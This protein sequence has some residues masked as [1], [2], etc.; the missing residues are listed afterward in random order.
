MDLCTAE[1][2][3]EK[4]PVCS[5]QSREVGFADEYQLLETD[6]FSC[7][8]CCFAEGL[9]H[10]SHFRNLPVWLLCFLE[11]TV[12]RINPWR[13]E[14]WC[15]GV[16]LRLC[17]CPVLITSPVTEMFCLGYLEISASASSDGLLMLPKAL[18]AYLIKAMSALVP[19]CLAAW[20]EDLLLQAAEKH[21]GRQRGWL[22]KEILISQVPTFQFIFTKG[23]IKLEGPVGTEGTCYQCCNSEGCAST[24]WKPSVFKW[25]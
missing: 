13:G 14:G 17:F 8:C 4:G 18:E 22:L 15:L 3:S 12:G 25:L 20:L 7:S 21:L 1:L 2:G 11:R 9:G 6:C 5:E 10:R 19:W 16:T 23:V 24:S